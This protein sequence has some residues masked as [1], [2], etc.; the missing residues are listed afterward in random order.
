MRY[1]FAVFF[2]FVMPLLSYGQTQSS[3]TPDEVEAQEVYLSFDY[4]GL[5]N[6]VITAYYYQDSIYLPLGTLFKQLKI[7]CVISPRDSTAKGFFI[8]ADDKYEIN[9]STN[10]AKIGKREIHFDK[11]QVIVKSLDFYLL[12]SLFARIFDLG[13]FVD[14]SS[15]SLSLVAPQGGAELPIVKEYEREMRRNY[16]LVSPNAQIIQAPLVYPRKR[17]I[18]NGGV[19]DYSLSAYRDNS[20]QTSYQYSLTGGAEILGGET[21]GTILGS[22]TNNRSHLYSS[23]ISWKY[24]FDSSNYI[25]YA[26]LGNL[27]TDGLSQLGFRG[28]QVSNEPVALRTLFTEYPIIAKTNP[29]WDVELYMNGQLVDYAKADSNGNAHFTVPLVYGTSF[30]QLKYYGPTGEI[31]EQDQRIQVPFT[32]VPS[33]EVNY[34]ISG[35]KLNNTDYNLASAN[36]MFGVTDWLTDKVGVDY[37]DDPLFSKPV[38]YNSAYVRIGPEYTLS[39]DLA[40]SAFYRSTFNALYSSQASFE[41]AYTKFAHNMLYNP[42]NETQQAEADVFFP[43]LLSR[44]AFNFRVAGTAQLYA[45]GQKT[46]SYS[47]F[48][49]S[50][51]AQFNAS[52]GYSKYLISFAGGRMENYGITASLLYSMFFGQGTFSFLNN[53]LANLNVRYGTLKNSL[54]D[55]RFELSKNVQ[56]Y[57]RVGVSAERDFVNRFTSFNLQI[58]ADL[59]FTRSTTTTQTQGRSSWYTENLSGSIGFDSNYGKFIFGNLPWVGHSAASMRLFV[60]NHGDGVFHEDDEVIKGGVVTLRQAASSETYDDGI[61]RDWNLLTYTQYSADVDVSSIKNPLWIPEKKSFSFITDPNSYKRIDIP[62]YVGGV[63]DGTVLKVED[64]KTYAI[65]GLNLEIA[66]VD[67]DFR[68]SINVFN[69]GS[70]YYMGL[71]PG[72]YIAYVDSTQLEILNV[73]QDPPV[74]KFKIRITKDGDYVEGLRILL[75]EKKEKKTGGVYPKEQPPVNETLRMEEVDRMRQTATAL[76]WEAKR[77]GKYRVLVGAFPDR[78]QGLRTAASA[79]KKIG[80]RFSTSF[81]SATNLYIVS[82]DVFENRRDAL[83]ALDSILYSFGFIDAYIVDG[84]KKHFPL[85]Y[86]VQ[87][88]KF[89]SLQ[90]AS[91]YASTILRK[92]G[93]APVIRYQKPQNKFLVLVGPF[94][95]RAKAVEASGSLRKQKIAENPYVVVFGPSKID[96]AFIIE[97]GKFS[98]IDST[99]A[100]LNQFRKETRVPAFFDFNSKDLK[101]NV[102]TYSCATYNEAKSL[103]EAIKRFKDFSNAYI[104]LLH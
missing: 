62:F 6:S 52:V 94:N 95:G 59:P 103:L 64:D 37:V 5:I 51:V 17:A 56:R 86:A 75:R 72:E 93:Y 98:G 78:E 28:G 97:V 31:V 39:L 4:N 20:H 54:D 11:S 10:V 44:S 46:Y 38:L 71:P 34:T 55:I 47:A 9:F 57:I 77:T 33:G 45:S 102:F 76:E 22:I 36:A 40:P 88:A 96:T 61:T 24:A 53:S 43:F 104:V 26:A 84:A 2:L 18:L 1:S 3:G 48:L 23:N 74:L 65:P 67:G 100:F 89:D 58:I 29:N 42:S 27:Y 63:I 66:S 30:I 99:K 16:L 92:T 70:F 83:V 79:T 101:F 8:N 32:F 15:L 87:L 7:N 41:M 50:S 82:S 60:D 68:K 81:N 90:R 85:L 25:S 35:G 69:D 19:L 13:F 14:F 91:L 73:E 12:P 80:Q 21:E 49:N